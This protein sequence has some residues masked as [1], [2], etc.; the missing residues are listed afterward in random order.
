MTTLSEIRGKRCA[1]LFR[2]HVKRKKPS[3]VEEFDFTKTFPNIRENIIEPLRQLDMAVDI[4]SAV[5]RSDMDEAL[6]EAL[7]PRIYYFFGEEIGQFSGYLGG[8][9][10]VEQA[11]AEYDLIVV[12]RLDML[13]KKPITEFGLDVEKINFL[14]KE[15]TRIE[16]V[17]D[18]F[19]AFHGDFLA[20]FIRTMEVVRDVE[21]M[22]ARVGQALIYKL[23]R[24]LSGGRAIHFVEQ[25]LYYSG[26]HGESAPNNNPIFRIFG[27][28]YHFDETS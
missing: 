2:G 18:T 3:F 6:L 24:M 22:D 8:L 11:N 25:E 19:H 28:P 23:M 27:P 10:L 16:L 20:P 9:R 12:S 15:P 7:Q 21:Y 26:T 17:C 13:F 1:V 5:H 14:W 4:Y